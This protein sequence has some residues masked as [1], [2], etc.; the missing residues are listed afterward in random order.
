MEAPAPL[1]QRALYSAMAGMLLAI[2]L[3]AL[4]QTAVTPALTAISTDLHSLDRLSWIVVAYFLTAT[5][6]TPIYGKLGDLH[7]RGRLMLIAIVVFVIASVL[8]AGAQT[9]V[10]LVV[11]RA[12]QGIGG[13]GLIVTAQ[14]MFADFISPRERGRFQA[15]IASMWA[16]AGIAGPPIGGLLAEH[17]SWRWIFWI[18]VP[19][20]IL[21][22][23]LCRRA[24]A[25]LVAPARASGKTDVGG[26]LLLIPAVSFVLFWIS[27]A[28]TAVWVLIAGIVFAV[29]FVAQEFRADE[30][31]LPPRLFRNGVIRVTSGVAFLVSVVQFSALVLLPVYFQVVD[32]LGVAAAGL[33]IVPMLIGIPIA[34]TT[35]GQIMVRS[36]RYKLILP[37]AC[38]LIA[39]A[40]AFFSTMESGT[41]RVAI[42]VAIGILGLGVGSTGPVLMTSTQNAS[43]S[44]DVGVATATIGFARALGASF[45]TALFW[46]VLLAD[47]DHVSGS[48]QPGFHHVFLIAAGIAV[49]TGAIAL[50]L[51]EET[52]KTAPR[53]NLGVSP[54]PRSA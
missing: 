43:E 25:R 2:M 1:G 42:V 9:L 34:A 17:A 47:R 4:D 36:G 50:F 35:S 22:F 29:A 31:V 38:A 3:A 7:G 40:F 6:L 41:S 18:N 23:I 53:T 46:S 27:E 20:G 51:R 39:A 15:Y 37:C 32:G 13:G 44:R 48:L 45:G 49:V 30:P 16:L 19:L 33:M 54:I 11:A 8:C 26:A 24:A 10:Q 28:G 14:A 21:T 12:L 5:T 52:L